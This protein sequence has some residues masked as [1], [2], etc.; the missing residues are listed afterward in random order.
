MICIICSPLNTPLQ[1]IELANC[2]LSPVDMAYLANSLHSEFLVKLDLSGHVVAE[3]FPN[4]FQK[5]LRRCSTTLRC[6]GLEECG[7]EDANLE[8]LC[9]ALEPCH[10]LEELKILGNPLSTEALR[11][12]F[13]ILAQGFS[14]LR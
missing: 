2:S 6:L 12:L 3:V 5:L 10:A 11:H 8:L 14:A 9:H 13:N 4:T 7:L 1:C